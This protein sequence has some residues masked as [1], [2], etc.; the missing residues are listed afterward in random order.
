MSGLLKRGNEYR[1]QSLPEQEPEALLSAED[2]AIPPDDRREIL[3]ELE[4]LTTEQRAG[5]SPRA[6]ELTKAARRG[7]LFPL[8]VNLAMALIAT[9]GL[10]GLYTYFEQEGRQHSQAPQEGVE[11]QAELIR[12]IQEQAQADLEDKER[13]IAAVEERLSDIEERRTNLEDRLAADIE[14]REQQLRSELEE[15]LEAERERL[16][17]AGAEEAEVQ[18]RIATLR[19]EGDADI[20]EE[21]D[22]LRADAEEER[23]ELDETLDE[24]ETQ[25]RSRL[26]ELEEERRR[27]T[28]EAEEREA[29]LRGRFEE[30]VEESEERLGQ[31]RAEL[32][33][34]A[35]RRERERHA[36]NQIVGYYNRIRRA[37]RAE[38][39]ET[40][41]D[42]IEDLRGYLSEDTVASLPAVAERRDTELFI[43]SSLETLL[44]NQRAERDVDTGDLLTRARAV[45]R[46]TELAEEA[47]TAA[48]AGND[49]EAAELHRAALDAVPVS[50]RSHEYLLSRLEAREG[51][52]VEE[53]RSRLTA[54]EEQNTQLQQENE[55]LSAQIA[56]LR[57]ELQQTEERLAGV[58]QER[59]QAEASLSEARGEAEEARTELALQRER[60]AARVE[61]VR[62]GL[63]G[64]L[65]RLRETAEEYRALETAY[66]AYAER[67]DEVL[68]SD[69]TES[70]LE[71]KPLLDSFLAS[72]PVRQVMPGLRDR[73]KAYDRAFRR[74]GREAALLDTVDVLYE[75]STYGGRQARLDYLSR[76][77]AAAEE[78]AMEEFLEQL[79]ELVGGSFE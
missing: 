65:R 47:R 29:E 20:E 27:I 52:R 53:L 78:T 33:T 1:K 18:E 38:D 58:R 67:E 5:L 15:Q 41:L 77:R 44:E 23:A 50:A 76:R 54:L 7:F 6:L 51:D 42:R 48:E 59:E 37:I 3:E 19:E 57:A 72:H 45:G 56:R 64:E 32:D 39:H 12:R 35:E 60:E 61:E 4:R 22:A 69:T 71:A 26:T 73:V 55:E 10:L 63:D 34:L 17:E 74:A 49:Q 46:A 24:L 79:E 14:R 8:L 43:L 13:E 9:G 68:A 75:L 70:R 31:A 16:R 25:F 21:L 2:Q 40:A 28:E 30:R 36:Q 66:D 62:Q 11:G